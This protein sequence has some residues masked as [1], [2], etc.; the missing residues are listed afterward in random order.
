MM[1]P[2]TTARHIQSTTDRQET[3]GQTRDGWTDRS[4][5]FRLP[6][7][8]VIAAEC[9]WLIKYLVIDQNKIETMKIENVKS[10]LDLQKK[11]RLWKSVLC[12]T[13]QPSCYLDNSF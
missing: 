6:A 8:S 13:R 9:I 5:D 11:M 10:I 7:S 3:G 2:R 12:R 4:A 1:G